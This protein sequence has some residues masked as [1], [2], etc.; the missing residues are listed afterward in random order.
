MSQEERIQRNQ[1]TPDWRRDFGMGGV[2]VQVVAVSPQLVQ[3]CELI[4]DLGR[5]DSRFVLL[6]APPGGGKSTL[7]AAALTAFTELGRPCEQI[8]LGHDPGSVLERLVQNKLDAIVVVDD[9]DRLN[10]SILRRL[11]AKRRNCQGLLLTATKVGSDISSVLSEEHD[12][13]LRV[14]RLEE[15]AD[16][17]LRV[18]GMMWTRLPMPPLAEA[19]DHSALTALREGVYPKGAWSLEVILTSIVELL[20]ASGDLVDGRLRRKITSSDVIPHLYR[21]MKEQMPQTVVA[22]TDAVLVV[23]GETD[24]VY[25]RRAAELALEQRGWHLLDGLQ[26]EAPTGRTGGGSAV[27]D[28]LLELRRKDVAQIGLFDRDSAGLAAYDMARKLGLKRLQLPAKFDPLARDDQSAVVEIEDLLPIELLDRYYHE[29]PDVSSEERHWRLGRWRIV[30]LGKDKGELAGWVCSVAS[31]DDLERCV[32]LLV[33][34]RKE[35][36][37]PSSAEMLDK[38]WLSRLQNRPSDACEPSIVST[39]PPATSAVHPL[40]S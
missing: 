29:H 39:V 18:A 14:P 10:A 37:L 13:Y 33:E 19:C 22:P 6:Q 12:R 28:R 4:D 25:L 38:R 32:Y 35:L 15:R 20:E 7:V 30:P 17:L 11:V 21:L 3:A 24:E 27:V 40:D 31:Y 34:L 5:G 9:C 8:R 26:I 23:E 2:P 16:D 36:G 1:E